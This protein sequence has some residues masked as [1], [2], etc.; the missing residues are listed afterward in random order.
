MLPPFSSGGPAAMF[1]RA[2]MVGTLIVVGCV[3]TACA[4]SC[5][6]VNTMNFYDKSGLQESESRI[7]AVGT[8]RIAG[9]EDENKQPMFNLAKVNCENHVD[10]TGKAS[11]ACKV[12]SARVWAGPGKPDTDSP[13]CSLDLNS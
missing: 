7:S 4:N 9:D 12:I 6:N 10:D 2:F 11:L 13:N 1:T 3:S 8:F 5:A